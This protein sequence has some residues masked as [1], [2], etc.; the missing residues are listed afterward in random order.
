MA[1]D[2][3]GVFHKLNKSNQQVQNF[4]KIVRQTFLEGNKALMIRYKRFGENI[5]SISLCEVVSL[6]VENSLKLV[7][8]DVV[9]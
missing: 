3:S 5:L 9:S 6:S 2:S 8:K 1:E 4:C 7:S